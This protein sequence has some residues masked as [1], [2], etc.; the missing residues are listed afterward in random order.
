MRTHHP[1]TIMSTW[2]WN[3]ISERK[4]LVDLITP[5]QNNEEYM[6]FSGTNIVIKMLRDTLC[7]QMRYGLTLG[8]NAC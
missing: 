7:T 8:R 6:T 3:T 5:P 1:Q 4:I 2:P